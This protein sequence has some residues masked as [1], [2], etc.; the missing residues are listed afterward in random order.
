MRCRATS[1]AKIELGTVFNWVRICKG[2]LAEKYNVIPDLSIYPMK[3]PLHS[4]QINLKEK[5]KRTQICQN[6]PSFNYHASSKEKSLSFCPPQRMLHFPFQEL[7]T[8]L[9]KTLEEEKLIFRGVFTTR[10]SRGLL[11]P[12][13]IKLP[14]NFRYAKIIVGWKKKHVLQEWGGDI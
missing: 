10:E 9:R 6:N 13:T 11:N 4:G 1:E 2:F 12:T 3:A 14:G 7:H 5:G 8:I